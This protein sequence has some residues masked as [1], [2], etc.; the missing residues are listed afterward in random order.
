[1]A[2]EKRRTD[3]LKHSND[4]LS[5]INPHPP[6]YTP[7]AASSTGEWVGCPEMPEELPAELPG[8]AVP[9]SSWRTA[10]MSSPLGNYMK[11]GGTI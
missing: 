4:D 6:S 7:M 10:G 2:D 8:N 11:M 1:M 9:P 5:C 3:H